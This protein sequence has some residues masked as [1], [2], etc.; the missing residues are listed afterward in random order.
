M[1]EHSHSSRAV[2]ATTPRVGGTI[3][4]DLAAARTSL[5]E[6]LDTIPADTP[7]AALADAHREAVDRIVA[8][9]HE[10]LIDAISKAGG[11]RY[12]WRGIDP[13][14][15]ADG[16]QPG[17]NIRNVFL[18]NPDRVEANDRPGGDATIRGAHR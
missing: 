15:K 7:A 18:F 12:E 16:G 5:L 10:Q 8:S 2:S 17:G 6:A 13:E 11:P 4:P 9:H 14:D 3:L 1:L